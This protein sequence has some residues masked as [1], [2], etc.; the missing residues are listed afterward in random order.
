MPIKSIRLH[1]AVAQLLK[2]GNNPNGYTNP[3]IQRNIEK[4]GVTVDGLKIFNRLHKIYPG[5][6]IQVPDWPQRNHGDFEQIKILRDEPEY[7][8]LF[9]PYGIVVEPGAGHQNQNLESW[10]NNEYKTRTDFHGQY[11]LVHR[12]DKN[13]QGLLLIAKSESAHNF[14]QD[15]FRGR[16]VVKKYLTLLHGDLDQRVEISGWQ[17]RDDQ[18]PLRQKFFWTESEAKEYSPQ[19]RFA[20]SM[21]RPLAYCEELNQSLAEV[22]IF[23]GRM[24]QIRLQAEALGHSLVADAVY[25]LKLK[26]EGPNSFNSTNQSLKFSLVERPDL[27][28]DKFLVL[29]KQLFGPLEYC[30]LSNYLKIKL[31][32]GST[33]EAEYLS[34]PAI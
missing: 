10:L 19:A 16:E 28:K 34:L 15:Q 7:L 25:N 13:T 21:F 6:N 12:L 3:E 1:Q 11:Y 30:L 20:H 22:Q 24:H 14:L 31:P 32:D 5:Q 18:K 8:L 26:V 17:S 4:Y 33:L 29:Q 23:T 2:E 27:E 9:K